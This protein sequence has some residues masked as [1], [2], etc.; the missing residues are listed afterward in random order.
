[1]SPDGSD[2]H[3]NGARDEVPSTTGVHGALHG[4]RIL[5]LTRVVAGPYA[6][7]LLADHGAEVIKVEQPGRG[8]ETRTFPPFSGGESTYFMS[9]NRNKKSIE[10]D[11]KSEAGYDHML[12]LAESSDV[13]MHN[14]RPAFTRARKL[15]HDSLSARNPR[16][17]SCAI[18]GFSNNGPYCD[19]PAY[20]LFVAGLGGLMSVTGEPDGPPQ[21]PGISLVDYMTGLQAALGT[22][23]ALQAV[24]T[25]GRGQSIEVSM[26]STLLSVTGV[27]VGAW[28]VSGVVPG[29]GSHNQSTQMVPYGTFAAA[30]GYVNVGIIKDKFWIPFC[31]II[32]HPEWR[33]DPRFVSNVDRVNNRDELL[34]LLR[35]I[36]AAQT[37]EHWIRALQAGDIPCGPILT[38]DQVI[39]DPE[40]RASGMFQTVEH[41]TAGPTLVAAPPLRMSATP[42]SI[43][44]PPPRLGEHSS[45][46]LRAEHAR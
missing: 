16:I 38:F 24:N 10:L 22:M 11:L 12:R 25:T 13:V 5:D 9:L 36:F 31:P 6:T 18:S 33:D 40:V 23:I 3:A 35:P 27:M 2:K 17:I 34:A 7:M 8:D 15:D 41:P 1:M 29:P 43:R 28:A 46:F 42:A 45:E 4:I 37:C 32:G 19:Q 20:D 44:T 21:R 14:F 26:L 39:D 30:D